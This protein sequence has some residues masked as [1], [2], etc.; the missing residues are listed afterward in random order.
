MRSIKAIN[1]P[2]SAAAKASIGCAHGADINSVSIS[3]ARSS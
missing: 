3:M 1:L 2:A